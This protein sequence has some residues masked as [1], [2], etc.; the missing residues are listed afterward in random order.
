MLASD[1][2]IEQTPN[3]AQFVDRPI[4]LEPTLDFINYL[5][6][7][8]KQMQRFIEISGLQEELQD[9]RERTIFVPNDEAF[10]S[11]PWSVIEQMYNNNTFLRSKYTQF[12]APKHHST[13]N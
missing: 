11:L 2:Q 4:Y 12:V 6:K 5:N 9:E 13:L 3:L 1:R 8:Y 10:R 7:N